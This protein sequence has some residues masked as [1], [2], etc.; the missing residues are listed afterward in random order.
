MIRAGDNVSLTGYAESNNRISALMRK[1]NDSSKFKDPNLT[2]VEAD[3]TLGEQGSRFEMQ[4]KLRA[5][6]PALQD[7]G[8]V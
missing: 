5:P 6:D 7:N 4:V 1:L 3:E 8:E 2:K